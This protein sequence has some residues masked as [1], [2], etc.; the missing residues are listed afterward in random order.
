MKE[1]KLLGITEEPKMY[2]DIFSP[3]VAKVEKLNPA[4]AKFKKLA[5]A[6]T[7]LFFELIE[8]QLAEKKE[9]VI[10]AM[11]KAC[12]TCHGVGKLFRL[13][14]EMKE[15]DCTVCGGTGEFTRPCKVCHGTGDFI[16]KDKGLT[17]K[18]HCLRCDK[19]TYKAKCRKCR[20][21]GKVQRWLFTGKIEQ[22]NLCPTCHGTGMKAVTKE[23]ENPAIPKDLG[24][25]LKQGL[26]EKKEEE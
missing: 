1:L 12:D 2:G 14:R 5:E 6:R 19:G 24:E 4:D 7:K 23:A 26:P 21:K 18:A 13:A 11:D 3:F 15:E 25:M 17:I 16:R 9:F 8:K 22:S 20:G 10:E